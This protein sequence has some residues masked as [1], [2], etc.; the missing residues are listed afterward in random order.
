MNRSALRTTMLLLAS[1]C[2]SCTLSP[3]QKAK[4]GT[5][6]KSAGSSSSSGAGS[7]GGGGGGGGG[8]S[9]VAGSGAEDSSGGGAF[10]IETEMFTYKAVEENS[11]VIACDI[12]RYLF[13]GDVTEAPAGSHVPC[14]VSNPSQTTPGIIL[15][16]SDSSL[17]SDF[18][19]WR[20]DMATMSALEA[21]ANDVCVA[22]EAKNENGQETPAQP[23]HMKSRGL[24]STI[25]S[26]SKLTPQGAAIGA[27]LQMFSSSQTVTSVVGTVQNPAL[28]NE[29]ARE[30]RSLNVLVLV[31]E[32]YNP[33]AL[34]PA[35][36]TNSPY[37]QNLSGFYSSYEKCTKAKAGSTENSADTASIDSVAAAMDS[38]MK[39]VLGVPGSGSAP[40]SP[41]DKTTETQFGAPSHLAAVLSADEVAKQ[42][43]FT[44]NG[45]AGPNST[46]QHVLWLKALE[47]GGSV[48]RQSNLFGTKVTFGGG[49]VD[50]YSVFRLNGQLVCS[51]N[52]FN[53]QTPV[54]TK[55]LQK[56]FRA[57][58][59]DNPAKRSMLHSTCATLPPS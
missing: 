31:P 3:A 24:G 12:A 29:V 53:F 13:Q 20:A 34:G 10:S 59:E 51:G 2:L 27:A 41:A 25:S 54:R 56:T 36:Y 42:M 19:L 22:P 39:A 50:T 15:I 49:A 23:P 32:L 4:S 38:F 30:L 35:D 5:S 52:V 47:S 18:Q 6:S 37:M 57:A 8:G 1:L 44:G 21:R 11:Q 46:W 26:L 17:I 14:L 16:S 40:G 7:A 43:G 28:V 33:N 45:S 58:P 9:S 48:N 55:D